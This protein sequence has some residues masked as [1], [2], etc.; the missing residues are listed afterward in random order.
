M[1][2]IKTTKE[3]SAL[4]ENIRQQGKKMSFVPT[5]GF[6][7][8]GHISLIRKGRVLGDILI[9]SIF[10]NPTQFGPA[11][12]FNTYPRDMER[13]I[14][15]LRKERVDFL[16][17]P[18]KEDLYP[19]RFGTYV[20]IEKLSTQLC[21]LSRPV[22]FKGVATIVAKLFNIVKP[23]VAVF[24]EKDYQ[25]VQVIRQMVLDLNFGIEIQSAPIVREKDGLAMSSRNAYL[26]GK[27][28]KAA[29]SLFKAIEKSR[30]LVKV[31]IIETDKIK[32]SAKKFIISYPETR[33][34]YI[35]IVD[36]ITLED[37]KII[38]K[39]ALMALAVFVGNTRLIDNTI[40][41]PRPETFS[42]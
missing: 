12:D 4:A 29:V 35:K 13:D 10:V 24:G 31:N 16:F 34:D 42:S 7:H 2:V 3:M 28:R 9:V 18:I 20:Y 38:E 6:L 26:T 40:L 39:P 37:I 30:E 25:Q 36:P 5:M 15:L 11:E 32:D 27:Q 21:G 1:K 8:E 22:F 41:N 33:I 19:E 17:T 14:E 23:H